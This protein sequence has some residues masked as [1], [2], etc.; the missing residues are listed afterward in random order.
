MVSTS[1]PSHN[2][3]PSSRYSFDQPAPDQQV[4]GARTTP[5]NQPY[6][7]PSNRSAEQAT[8]GDEIVDM[9]DDT[10]GISNRLIGC[11]LSLVTL[12][13]RLLWRVIE[14]EVTVCSLPEHRG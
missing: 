8:V 7:I 5:Q 9:V 4:F 6:L 13:F 11:S 12:P 2:D 10:F 14:A 3:D 1:P